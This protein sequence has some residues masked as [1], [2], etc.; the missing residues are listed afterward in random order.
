MTTKDE[1]C[2]S[3]YIRKKYY[4]NFKNDLSSHSHKRIRTIHKTIRLHGHE[5]KTSLHIHRTYHICVVK[6]MIAMIIVSQYL[7][8]LQRNCC[9][10]CIL[11]D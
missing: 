8:E 9:F 6:I 2:E 4:K 3:Y 10:T 11:H 7:M 5:K 1:L